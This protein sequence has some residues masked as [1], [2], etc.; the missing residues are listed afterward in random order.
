M[1]KYKRYVYIS[2]RVAAQYTVGIIFTNF[3]YIVLTVTVDEN[4][5]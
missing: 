2:F 4:L 5:H 3:L 1:M